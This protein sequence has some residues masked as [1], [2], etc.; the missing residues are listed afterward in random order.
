MRLKTNNTTI[1]NA[2]VLECPICGFE[3]IHPIS[4]KVATGE[5]VTCI[6]AQ[7]Q[8][9][10]WAPT[11]ETEIAARQQGIRIYLEYSCE[12]G[13]HRGYIIFQFHKG[14]TLIEHEQLTEPA[15]VKTLWRT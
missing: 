11:P 4:V 9:T 14:N 15:E 1:S 5:Y 2:E 7:G 8:E 6:D 12:N 10:I 3:C 13:E